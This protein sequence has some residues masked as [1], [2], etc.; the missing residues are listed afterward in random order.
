MYL[1]IDCVKQPSFDINKKSSTEKT[2]T[3]AV[4]PGEQLKCGR[5]RK[6]P[7]SADANVVA[8]ISANSSSTGVCSKPHSVEVGEWIVV[9]YSIQ[10]STKTKAFIGQFLAVKRGRMWASFLRPFVTRDNFGFVY[11][12]PRIEDY[13]SFTFSQIV[14]KL[15]PPTTFLRDG[16]FLFPINCT[17]LQNM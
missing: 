17:S 10:G 14:K 9:R 3:V 1:Y 11:A 4:V 6:I 8:A 2:V 16:N 13:S 5:P 15:E 7:A 12:Y